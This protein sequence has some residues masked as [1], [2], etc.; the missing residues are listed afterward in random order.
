LLHE[1]TAVGF[2]DRI[3]QTVEIAHPAAAEPGEDTGSTSQPPVAYV[4]S[5]VE[6]L[7]TK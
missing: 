5:A 1:E 3:E 7:W 6:D 2:P 4:I